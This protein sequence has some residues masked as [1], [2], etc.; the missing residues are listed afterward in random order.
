M[1]ELTLI[2][3]EYESRGYVCTMS[4]DEMSLICGDESGNTVA[5][6]GYIS[7]KDLKKLC[8]GKISI[9]QLEAMQIAE[10]RNQYEGVKRSIAL[11]RR[12]RV[13]KIRNA[14][15]IIVAA[16]LGALLLFLQTI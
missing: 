4:N 8:R 6:A 12:E 2:R 13:K 5:R 9:Y 3:D 15:V 1:V 10:R 16:S 7:K 11:M 14:V